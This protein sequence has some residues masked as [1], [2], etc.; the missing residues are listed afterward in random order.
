[1]QVAQ[2]SMTKRN[3]GHSKEKALNSKIIVCHA[4]RAGF[5][6][7]S[8]LVCGH[9]VEGVEGEEAASS[10]IGAGVFVLEAYGD[11]LWIL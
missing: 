7:E 2:K 5:L 11:P 8:R 4:E 10:E 3:T 1:M 9:V 6:P